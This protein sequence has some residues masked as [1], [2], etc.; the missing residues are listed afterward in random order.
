[1]R[2]GRRGIV[3]PAVL[4][5]LV[6]LSAIS[7]L[8]LME[9]AQELRVSA[10]ASDRVVARAGAIEGLGHVWS[11]SDPAE[12]CLRPPS[13]PRTVARMASG[14]GSI[15]IRWHHLGRGLIRADV[16]GRGRRGAVTRLTAHLRP[17]S[18]AAPPGIG[19][20]SATSLVPATGD[21]L[22]GHPEG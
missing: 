10:L 12:L 20:P 11:P 4:A 5:V 1:M 6:P 2:S 22:E 7:A 17:D 13:L 8:A 9:A 18:V 3:L 14:G 16:E 15:I 21:W 19:C